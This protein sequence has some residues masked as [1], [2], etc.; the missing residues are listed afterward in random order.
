MNESPTRLEKR[1]K[2]AGR[3]L[4]LGVAISS[5]TLVWHHPLSFM[6]FATVGGLLVVGGVV[7]YL[8]AIASH[9]A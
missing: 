9:E 3:L 7:T 5:G 6:L 4:I 1:F 2:L 8:V